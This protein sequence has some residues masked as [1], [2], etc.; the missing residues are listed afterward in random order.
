MSKTDPRKLVCTAC[1]HENEVERV[2]C[3]NC[4][5]KLDRSLLPQLDESQTADAMAKSARKMKQQM[6]PNRFAWVRSIK[7][8]VLIEIFAAVVAAVFLV[9]QAPEN[10]PPTKF[11][12]SDDMVEVGDVWT[13]M[14]NTRAPVAVTFK[15]FDVNYYLRN[16]VKGTEGP[17]GIKFERAFVTLAPGL[18]TLVNQRNAWGLPIYNSVAFKPELSG[19][20]WSA[21]VQQFA[22]GR[23]SIP[24]AFAK[25]VKL[26]AV[27]L[28][29]L[30]KVFEKETQQLDRI[31][32]I[33][34]GEKVIFFKTK[35][36]Q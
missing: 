11:V 21:N 10:V 18:V 15:E 2:Y 28:G 16:A 17:L 6:N 33:E 30:S 31:A 8:F 9:I 20:K 23:L 29:A 24:P 26:D 3:H 14:M 27:T 36:A 35:P 32:V 4:G 22:I 34:P 19:A 12:R 13:G 7:T 1:K 25:L 5:E